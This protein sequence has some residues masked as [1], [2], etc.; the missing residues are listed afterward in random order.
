MLHHIIN[1]RFRDAEN[2]NLCFN[3][4]LL[5]AALG[6]VVFLVA[7]IAQINFTIAARFAGFVVFE[8]IKRI[9]T[10]VETA[11]AQVGG[12]FLVG[13]AD[14]VLKITAFQV[15]VKAFIHFH[16]WMPP[17]SKSVRTGR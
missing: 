12:G 8:H 4:N 11:I 9:F 15:F 14:F 13:F 10:G 3:G 7:D 6:I 1:R 17:V 2:A 16:G 5:S